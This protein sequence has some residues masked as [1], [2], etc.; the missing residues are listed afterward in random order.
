MGNAEL[1]TWNGEG[2]TSYLR[3]NS[4]I[5]QFVDSYLISRILPPD[6]TTCPR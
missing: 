3:G 2:H 4:C 6:G 5:D 1:L